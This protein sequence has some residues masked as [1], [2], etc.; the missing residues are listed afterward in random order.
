MSKLDAEVRGEISGSCL[1]WPDG[2]KSSLQWHGENV[3]SVVVDGETHTGIVGEGRIKWGDGDTWFHVDEDEDFSF[4][5]GPSFLSVR[6]SID[7]QDVGFHHWE[8]RAWTPKSVALRPR[9]VGIDNAGFREREC[10][11]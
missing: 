8:R 3:V 7:T 9:R 1:R 2:D 5:A 4:D 10:M 6:S 11:F